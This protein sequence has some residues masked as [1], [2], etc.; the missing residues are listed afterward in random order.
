MKAILKEKIT[1]RNLLITVAILGYLVI[2]LLIVGN[3]VYPILLL[4]E[5]MD[6]KIPNGSVGVAL[7]V[8]SELEVGD[9][10]VFED[11]RTETRV[12]HT[13]VYEKDGE[14]IVK[15]ENNPQID[16]VILTREDIHGKILFSVEL[17]IDD[18]H[19]W[20]LHPEFGIY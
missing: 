7:G 12:I 10:V 11:P 2:L 13:I 6:P 1:R 20:K 16:G 8:E 19:L 15:G 18:E 17:P 5:S 14:Y 9:V 3:V 4:G